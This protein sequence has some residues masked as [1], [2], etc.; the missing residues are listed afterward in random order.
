[1]NVTF[2]GGN[3]RT[4]GETGIGGSYSWNDSHSFVYGQTSVNTS[5]NN[6]ADS[7]ELSAK[8]GLRMTW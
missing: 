3:D 8:I 2:H 5:L 7:Y 4:W 6:F 1:A